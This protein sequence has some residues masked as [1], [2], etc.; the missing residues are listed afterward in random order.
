MDLIASCAF[1]LE[2]PLRWELNDLGYESQVQE[3][4][5][6]AFSGDWPDVCR[7]NTWLRI[8]DRIQI[9]LAEFACPDFDALFDTVRDFDWS[10]WLPIDAKFVVHA[11][12]RQSQLTSL[13]AIQR[14][15]KRAMVE[16]MFRGHKT[17]SLPETGPEFRIETVLLRD[18]ARI[19]LDTTGPSLHKRSYRKLVGPAPIKETLA[20]ALVKLSVWNHERTL[21]DPFCGS[22]TIPIEAALIGLNI[23]PG[24]QPSVCLRGLAPNNGTNVG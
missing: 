2:T 24:A 21:V 9:Q 15:T 8:A 3:P 4:G 12:S 11:R 22:G 13:P 5:Q 1:A 14:A 6:V 19:M 10:D 20:A 17:D 7:C 23:A 18:Q 16:S